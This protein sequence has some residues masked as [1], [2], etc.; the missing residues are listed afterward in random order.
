[1]ANIIDKLGAASEALKA[2]KSLENP[3]TWKNRQLAMNACLTVVG[4][5]PIFLPQIGL[6]DSNLNVIAL[7]IA[8]IGGAIVNSY[9]TAA[10]S[11]KVG[12][13]PK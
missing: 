10:T 13:T 8:T 2:G 6:T 11:D 4:L 3:E 5:V 12:F 1:M 9:F 7:A